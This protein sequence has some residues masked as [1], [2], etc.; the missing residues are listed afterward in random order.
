MKKPDIQVV[1]LSGVLC[2]FIPLLFLE[3]GFFKVFP[4]TG[5][6]DKMN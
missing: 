3:K 4:K 1:N 5:F 2:E 6:V